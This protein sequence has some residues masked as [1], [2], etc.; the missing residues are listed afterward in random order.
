[1][2]KFLILLSL[3]IFIP[4]LGCG[5]DTNQ[6]KEF[7]NKTPTKSGTLKTNLLPPNYPT[8]LFQPYDVDNNIEVEKWEMDKLIPLAKYNNWTEDDVI[9]AVKILKSCNIEIERTEAIHSTSS[10]SYKQDEVHFAGI[11]ELHVITDIKD[12]QSA[13][14]PI[15]KVYFTRGSEYYDLYVGDRN[16]GIIL[17]NCKDVF[18]KQTQFDNMIKTLQNYLN[19]HNGKFREVP[20]SLKFIPYFDGKD[21]KDILYTVVPGG[22]PV[23]LPS[24]VYGKK[25]E[26]KYLSCTFDNSGNLIDV[27]IQD[28]KEAMKDKMKSKKQ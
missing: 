15:S 18:M 23:L 25:Y 14:L 16:K 1:M 10:L 17:G 20:G 4:I 9:E 13:R 6:N 11:P 24:K 28:V 27:Y 22:I 8:K 3:F 19:E 12:K 21:K 2:K 5:N 26:E 7:E